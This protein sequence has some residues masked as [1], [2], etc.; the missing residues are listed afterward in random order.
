VHLNVRF[1]AGGR[2]TGY[3]IVRSSGDPKVDQSV[4]AAAKRANYVAGLSAEFL[5]KYP[6]LTIEM[7]PTRQ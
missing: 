5:K 7:K 4:L 1:G 2:I 6:E 3:R